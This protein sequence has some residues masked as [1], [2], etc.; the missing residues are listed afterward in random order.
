LRIPWRKLALF[1]VASAAV[2]VLVYRHSDMEVVHARAAEFHPALAF[3]LL[4]VLPLFGVPVSILHIAAGIRFGVQW[5]LVLV[6]LSIALQLI[7]SYAIV[8][9]WQARFEAATWIRA[10]RQRIPKGTHASITT[11]T[12]LLPGAPYVAINYLLPLLGVPLRY[13]LLIAY[14]IHT[15]RSTV[16]VTLGD[17]SDQLTPVR[18]ALLLA[19]WLTILTAC[20]LL[21]RRV[22]KQLEDPPPVADGRRQP[23]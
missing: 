10:L 16:T 11:V 15:I 17:Q 14:P 4:V 1:A 12:V 18:L 8:H 22:R 2:A 6:S 5:G 21:Y 23:A 13:L 9:L 7:G 20:S 3:G 19:Y